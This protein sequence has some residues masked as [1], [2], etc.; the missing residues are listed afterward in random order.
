MLGANLTL[1]ARVAA[2]ASVVP[3]C[4]SVLL[5]IDPANVALQ[6]RA[7]RL[8]MDVLVH[9]RSALHAVRCNG[10]LRRSSTLDA[11]SNIVCM[12]AENYLQ[13][14]SDTSS[15][16]SV[17]NVCPAREATV[18][19]QRH[20]LRHTQQGQSIGSIHG[21]TLRC[22]ENKANTHCVLQN[23]NRSSLVHINL[24]Q[25]RRIIRTDRRCAWPES[26]L[27]TVEAQR[28]VVG[29]SS[30]AAAHRAPSARNASWQSS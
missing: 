14:S 13:N 10:S 28:T 12:Q 5:S 8:E 9:R 4:L 2:S 17:L 6:T 25:P 27:F 1:R 16:D 15:S 30:T 26:H 3:V 7:C 19:A 11:R 18:V 24:P 22:R 23:I 29:G 21:D 20:T